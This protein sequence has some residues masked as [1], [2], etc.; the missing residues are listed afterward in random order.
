M[1]VCVCSWCVFGYRWLIYRLYTMHLSLSVVLSLHSF[2]HTHSLLCLSV[3]LFLCL[4]L[5]TVCYISVTWTLHQHLCSVEPH[6]HTSSEKPLYKAKIFT[7]HF[8]LFI[9]HN[10]MHMNQCWQSQGIWIIHFNIQYANKE[11]RNVYNSSGACIEVT[12]SHTP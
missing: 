8:D 2:W 11:S 4:P 12:P 6:S 5:P 10:L 3:L 9:L 7:W 1:S